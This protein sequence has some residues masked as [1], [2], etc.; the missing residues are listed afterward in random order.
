MLRPGGYFLVI[1]PFLVQVHEVPQT[2]VRGGRS[3]G[4]RYFLADNGFDLDAIQTGLWGNL[5]CVKA[6]L[7]AW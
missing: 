6:T 2:I 4:L 1:T 7:V 3:T 5:A